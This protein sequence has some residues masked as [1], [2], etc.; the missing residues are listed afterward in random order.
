MK[1]IA[2]SVSLALFLTPAF[3]TSVLA[4]PVIT[5]ISAATGNPGTS[6]TINGTNFNTTL[7]DN[8][9]YFGPVKATVSAATA[10][11]LSV[12]VPY[13]A[14]YM[15]VSVENSATSL[16]G[17]SQ[18]PFLPTYNNSAYRTDTVYFDARIDSAT[19]VNP[20]LI[21][22]GDLDGDGKPDMVITNLG[23]NT[24]SVYQ[25]TSTG[26]IISF[27]ARVDIAT[28]SHPFGV[29]ISDL[30]G[31]GKLDVV[32]V[33][34]Y[35]NTISVYR[36]TS[37]SGVISF[38]THVD[39]ST[40]IGPQY[41]AIGDLDGD[42]KPDIVVTDNDVNKVSVIQNTSTPG[43]T[44]FS[45]NVDFSTGLMP[46]AVAIADLDGD[47]KPDIVIP[48]SYDSV[49]SIYLNTS[50]TG[51]I[52]SSSFATPVTMPGG[53]A[54]FG[55]AVGDLDGDGKPDIGIT[56]YLSDNIS[57]YRNTSSVGTLSFSPRV[58]F[59][60][61]SGPCSIKMGDI[62]GDGKPDLA[63]VNYHSNTVSV[64]RNTATSGSITT[65]SFA[66]KID[67][68][69]GAMPYALAIGDLNGDGKPELIVT[70]DGDSTVSV[71]LNDPIASLGV[72]TITNQAA[73]VFQLYPNPTSS[74]FTININEAGTFT[75]Y[76]IDG[77]KM[78]EYNVT[79]GLN[80]IDIP[81]GQ[82]S[83]IYIGK[84]IG[85][86]GNTATVRVVYER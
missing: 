85:R 5:S 84:Y 45:T 86:H 16:M 43:T 60:V 2:L 8:I 7:A 78:N 67:F 28:G 69:T 18:Y 51:A 19:G 58:N 83:G 63:V 52:S 30:D 62:N 47:G 44:S 57:I 29:A 22:L 15:P 68:A 23:S 3:Q 27:A 24:M 79:G 32:A 14:T 17:Y 9:V 71:L 4:Q 59:V 12:T 41:V 65:T 38:D 56:N 40:G 75:L 10:T 20:Y 54:A 70:N 66:A 39:F 74:S 31:D 73:D 35:D 26:G 25:N 46:V 72:N 76:S 55:V 21:A 48:S 13:G 53:D 11:S 61:D 77:K 64:F 50:V 33:N 36:N 37:A 80:I 42:G 82:A 34:Q 1:R 6:I 81:Q 49:V